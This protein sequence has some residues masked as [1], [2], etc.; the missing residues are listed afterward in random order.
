[1]GVIDQRLRED[2]AGLRRSRHILVLGEIIIA[3]CGEK[4]LFTC[5]DRC[6]KHLIMRKVR[7]GCPSITC[8]SNVGFEGSVHLIAPRNTTRRIR[9]R[10]A[11]KRFWFWAWL[12]SLLHVQAKPNPQSRHRSWLSRP[13]TRCN[14][15]ETGPVLKAGPFYRHLRFPE[16]APC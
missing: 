2:A 8:L 10:R 16:Q 14:S 6:S 13:R 11:S 4:F 12:L 9:C 7:L 3:V 1:M 5:V 15:L